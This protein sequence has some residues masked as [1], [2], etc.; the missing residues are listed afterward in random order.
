MSLLKLVDF[1]I[2]WNK[3][4]YW[5]CKGAGNDLASETHIKFWS[6]HL[7][8][9]LKAI[10]FRSPSRIRTSKNVECIWGH[11][12]KKFNNWLCR[13]WIWG[14]YTLSRMY[15][16]IVNIST[17]YSSRL[18]AKLV[19]KTLH[20]LGFVITSLYTN[21][22]PMTSA[23]PKDKIAMKRIFQTIDEID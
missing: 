9:R 21:L 10:C 6:Q 2:E 18:V 7:Q 8:I 22:L 12:W 16:T 19:G 5:L 20:H 13:N 11:I 15:L 23:F 3:T 4:Q 14:F 1:S 17:V